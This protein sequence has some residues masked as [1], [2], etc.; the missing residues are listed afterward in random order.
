MFCTQRVARASHCGRVPPKDAG[1]PQRWRV[2]EPSGASWLRR[3]A[4]Q[5]HRRACAARAEGVACAGHHVTCARSH[6]RKL[7][8]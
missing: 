4:L 6:R 7:V 5:R 2:Q 8:P 1:V 3:R